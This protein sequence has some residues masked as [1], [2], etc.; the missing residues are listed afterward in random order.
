MNDSDQFAKPL[1]VLPVGQEGYKKC[2]Q[3]HRYK[4]GKH[5]I[6]F[7]HRQRIVMD[8]PGKQVDEIIMGKIN[9]L[10]LFTQKKEKTGRSSL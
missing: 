9:P 8:R 3:E 10:A 2:K 1:P 6:F 4:N 7:G 5:N